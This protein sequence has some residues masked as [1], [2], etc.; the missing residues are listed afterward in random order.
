MKSTLQARPN[1]YDILGLTPAASADEIARAFA[2]ELSPLRPHAFGGLALVSLAY[3]VLRDPAKRR[4]YDASLGVS[5]ERAPTERSSINF[6]NGRRGE[7]R[8]GFV[9]SA[10]LRDR[11]ARAATGSCQNSPALSLKHD[12][13]QHESDAAAER[14]RK[15]V[16]GVRRS[17]PEPLRNPPIDTLEWKRPGTVIAALFLG[18]GLTGALAGL[19][20]D[21]VFAPQEAS[22]AVTLP[23]GQPLAAT[24]SRQAPPTPATGQAALVPARPTRFTAPHL[25]RKA[26]LAQRI[27]A[28]KQLRSGDI[29]PVDL[30]PRLRRAAQA[31][32]EGGS[33][34]A[35]TTPASAPALSPATPAAAAAALPLPDRIVARTIEK[36][37][38]ACGQVN[39]ATPLDGEPGAFKVTCTSGDSY[40][41]APVRGRYH[42]RR[43]RSSR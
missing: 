5:R 12:R 38:Y 4:A 10:V 1:H 17:T 42:F 20:S 11:S 37:G 14:R 6:G 39:S 16:V 22:A 27:T 28:P 36:I 23:P 40:K 15:E 21:R 8:S 18:V 30:P 33:G 35:T 31:S 2:R 26:A 32:G 19:W 13:R 43:L 9:I 34:E 7:R 29:P 41:A 3:E 24:H 25:R